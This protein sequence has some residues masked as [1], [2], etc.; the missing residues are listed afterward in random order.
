MKIYEEEEIITIPAIEEKTIVKKIKKYCCD[1]CEYMT[2]KKDSL[3][4]HIKE[5]HSRK[6]NIGTLSIPMEEYEYIFQEFNDQETFEHFYGKNWK[7][8]GWYRIYSIEVP[9]GRGCCSDFKTFTQ[10]INEFIKDIQRS[11]EEIENMEN[12]L[13]IMVTDKQ[14]DEIISDWLN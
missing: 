12:R 3:F 6:E 14:Y 5:K 8:K 13:R 7:G 2:D 4:S 11:K 1:Y 9:C 10:Y